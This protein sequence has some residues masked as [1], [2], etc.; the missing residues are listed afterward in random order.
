M[1]KIMKFLEGLTSE[2]SANSQYFEFNCRFV[3]LE[4]VKI[5]SFRL[6][7]PPGSEGW[8]LNVQLSE[9]EVAGGGMIVCVLFGNYLL[10]CPLQSTNMRFICPLQSRGLLS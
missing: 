9:G 5:N 7:H 8:V 2:N 4:L 1:P 10:V 3:E 6:K